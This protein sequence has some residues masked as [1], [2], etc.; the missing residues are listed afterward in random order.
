MKQ[1]LTESLGAL[2][3]ADVR[4]TEAARLAA[5]LPDDDDASLSAFA[6]LDGAQIDGALGTLARRG[7]AL[8]AELRALG[9]DDARWRQSRLPALAA[10]FAELEGLHGELSRAEADGSER[11]A[12]ARDV[13][14]R[15]GALHG[16]QARVADTLAALDRLADVEQSADV[17]AAAVAGADY[18]TAVA[19]VAKLRAAG[20]LG[21][22]GGERG[23]NVAG[24]QDLR[25]VHAELSAQ[26][27]AELERAVAAAD[28]AAVV[29]F[30]ALLPP[31]GL[32]DAAAAAFT[33]WCD[34]QLAASAAADGAAGERAAAAR[35]RPPA[36]GRALRERRDRLRGQGGG[37]GGA[38]GRAAR[39]QL[40]LSIRDKSIELASALTS[41][42]IAASRLGARTAAAAAARRPAAT[43][44]VGGAAAAEMEAE[45]ERAG[46][47]CGNCGRRTRRCPP[48]RCAL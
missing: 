16:A 46:L 10:T 22:G 32:S 7:A 38:E 33:T 11:A 45:A 9:D 18:E 13:S 8:E 44:G 40:V 47:E 41:E 2:A 25:S 34:A 23:G 24:A 39:V 1:V 27:R 4:R 37:G 14:G 35:R 20:A 12:L 28:G 30:A 26:V 3:A 21:G 42:Y 31:L 29:R 19:H 48:R 43:I 6:A 17:V 5:A 15:V 36:R